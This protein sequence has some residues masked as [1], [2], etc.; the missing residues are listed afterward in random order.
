MSSFIGIDLGTTFCAVSTLDDT[1]RPVIVRNSDGAN[2]TPSCL[3]FRDGGKIEVGEDARRTYG[4]NPKV[5]GRFKRDM[6]TTKT[7]EVDG[8]S[9]TP[10]DLSSL[11]LKKLLKDTINEVGSV[12]EAV[13]TIP[14]NFSNDARDATMQA[15]KNAGLNV[16]Y[17]VNEPTAAALYYAFHTGSELNGNYAV[18]DL[19][20]GTFDI[21]ILHVSGQDI[22]VLR[23]NGIAR[24]G[25]DD[26]D[27]ALQKLVFNKTM[28]EFGH[29]LDNEDF[30]LCDAEKEKISLSKRNNIT[31]NL[32]AIKKNIKISRNDFEEIISSSL[33]QMQMACESVVSESKMEMSD[34]TAVF[35]VGG[36]SRIPAVQNLVEKV[37]KQKPLASVNVDEVVALGASLYAAYKGDQSKLNPIQKS[38]ISNI[39][40]GESTSKFFG[41]TSLTGDA[42]G[43]LKKINSIIIK[44]GE[45]IP[46]TVSESF[47]T[48]R[49]GQTN[50]H[51]D[52]TE[53]SASETDPNFVKVIWEGNLELPDGRPAGQEIKVTYGYDENQIMNCTFIDVDTGKEKVVELGMEAKDREDTADIDKF[54][55]E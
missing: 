35:L 37:F 17:I 28:D 20:G 6:G 30:P 48:I 34:I 29:E 25:G 19:G 11:L 55:V 15:A 7:Y 41:T 32:R 13:V 52:V 46:C 14:A 42:M 36:S 43:S 1:G 18:F 4:I 2:I 12:A 8:E 31:I 3:E 24:L 39:K 23:S 9:F 47:Y 33:V 54:L 21:S 51:C 44:K 26:F 22:D 50:V 5:L 16:K 53:S 10:T 45:K 40:V 49:D 27:R 38:S